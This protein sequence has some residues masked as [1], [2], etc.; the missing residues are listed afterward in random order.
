MR[1][2][3]EVDATVLEYTKVVATSFGRGDKIV[4]RLTATVA[5]ERDLRMIRLLR[6]LTIE[7]SYYVSLSLCDR[8]GAGRCLYVEGKQTQKRG[9]TDASTFYYHVAGYPATCEP[10]MR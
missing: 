10:S 2:C 9:K 1:L 6:L 3:T 4:C 7:K 5:D 8:T